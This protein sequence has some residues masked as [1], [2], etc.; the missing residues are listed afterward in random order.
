M[1]NNLL[2][3]L[4][5]LVFKITVSF[6]VVLVGTL[7][8]LGVYLQHVSNI[9]SQKLQNELNQLKSERIHRLLDS[10]TNNGQTINLREVQKKLIEYA[11]IT[12]TNIKLYDENNIEVFDTS[13]GYNL[14]NKKRNPIF[15]II[16]TSLGGMVV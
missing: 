13:K 11:T 7:L 14:Q 16:P 1:K 9:E 6:S 2:R 5:S 4:N 8:S 10:V 3:L 12:G 15:K